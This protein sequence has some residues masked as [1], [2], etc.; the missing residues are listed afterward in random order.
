MKKLFNIDTYSEFEL[1]KERKYQNEI[2]SH[3][4][5]IQNIKKTYNNFII[6][7]AGGSINHIQAIVRS[8]K[9]Y[10]DN[11]HI[12]HNANNMNFLNITKTIN[13]QTFLFIITKNGKSPEVNE[14]AK[15]IINLLPQ[16][17]DNICIIATNSG[18]NNISFANRCYYK[19]IHPDVSG[20]FSCF[21]RAFILPMMLFDDFK[22]EEYFQGAVIEFESDLDDNILNAYQKHDASISVI[23]SYIEDLQYDFFLWY[24]QLLMES[25][26]K[27]N[28]GMN[29]MFSNSIVDLHSKYQMFLE[30]R[31][32]K[33]FT[34]LIETSPRQNNILDDVIQ[35]KIKIV[36]DLLQHRGNIVREIE[37]KELN[38]FEMGRLFCMFAK[39]VIQICLLDGVNPFNQP[40]IE[41]MKE[42][43]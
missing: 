38:A 21:S 24:E 39:E 14:Y 27:N 12:I 40:A 41:K 30:G 5:F 35:K 34:I 8:L 29:A 1:L 13:E 28:K 15:Y 37:I 31:K 16:F 26:G 2:D 25:T 18:L 22:I 43:E 3:K 17:K 6:L 32:D 42:N 33:V 11:I 20:R 7:G 4:D 10:S 23:C 9:L 19:I 36:K